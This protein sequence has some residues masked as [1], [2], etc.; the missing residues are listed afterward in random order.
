[1]L[2][3][4]EKQ[5][6]KR[7]AE[8]VHVVKNAKLEVL[9]RSQDEKIAKLETTYAD[10]KREKDNVTTGYQR[11]AAKHDAFMEKAEQEKAKLA[12]VHVVELTKL[13]GDLDLETH[14][15]TAYHQTVCRRLR[16]LHEIVASSFDEVKAQCLPFPDKGAKVEEMINWVVGK[17]KVVTD[18]VWW[19]NDNFTVLGIEGILNMLNGEGCQELNR[20]H[21]LA[22]SCNAAILEDV[23]ED[24]HR[25]AGWIVR[26]WWKQ[27]GLS[28]AL[29][30][31]EAAHAVAVSYSDN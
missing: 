16:E 6:V 18:T 25:L 13:P 28:E 5:H 21:D 31:L 11:L 15:Y 22:A 7:A 29:C 9:V 4:S 26:R 24:V 10:L 2:A 8:S 1:V 23:P 17:V 3:L 27:H 20:L 30:R 19:L 14:N 12:E